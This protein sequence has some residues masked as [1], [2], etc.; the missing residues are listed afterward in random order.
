MAYLRFLSY[1]IAGG[2]FWVFLF[3]LG[4]YYFGNLPVVKEN[5]TLVILAIIMVSLLPGFFEL[6]RRRRGMVEEFES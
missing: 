4:G 3:L 5:F 2:L 1:S 6:I